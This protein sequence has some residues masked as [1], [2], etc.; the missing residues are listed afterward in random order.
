MYIGQAMAYVSNCFFINNETTG[1]GGGIH[2]SSTSVYGAPT[3]TDC[4]FE[5]NES[6]GSDGGGIY[7]GSD[8]SSTYGPSISNCQFWNNWAFSDG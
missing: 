3:I 6:T 1:V 5:D 4:T 8:I 7:N 2:I